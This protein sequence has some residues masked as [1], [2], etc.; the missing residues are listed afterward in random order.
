MTSPKTGSTSAAPVPGATRPRVSRRI[1]A[2]VLLVIALSAVLRLVDLGRYPETVFDEHYYV[3][4]AVA[5]LHGDLAGSTAQPWKPAALRSS[6][7][8]DLAKLAIAAG[9][10]VFGDNAW[11]WRLPAALAGIALIALVFPLGRRLGLSDEWALAALV[12]AASDPML[13]LE[14]R[15]AV[16]DVFV[17]LGTAAAVYLA[18]RFVQSDFAVGWLFACGAA[19]GAAVAC[20]WSGLLAVPAVLLV[21]MPPLC[22][23]GRGRVGVPSV[24]AALVATPLAVYLAASIPYF[25]AGHGLSDWLRLQQYMAKFGWGVK[26]DRSFA[27]RPVTW[28]FDAYPIWFKWSTGSGGTAGLL[29]IGNFLLWWMG[30]A[31]WVVLSLLAIL[32]RDWRAGLAPALVAVLYLPWLLTSRQTYIYYMVPAVPFIAIMVAFGLSR[33]VGDPW[34]PPPGAQ[35]DAAPPTGDRRRR[36]RLGAWAFCAACVAVGALYVPFVLGTPVPFDY[37]VFLTPFTTWK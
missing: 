9:I 30:I 16:L 23:R 37:Y 4:D 28:P 12:L 14:S 5:I 1:L 32:R 6:A 18:L 36:R 29:A 24:L 20:K 15:L 25:A 33:L 13:M 19:V 10:E 27:S 3:H 31:T 26:G 21:L 7:H 8:P 34:A 11:G 17:A 22:R 2:V 35:L